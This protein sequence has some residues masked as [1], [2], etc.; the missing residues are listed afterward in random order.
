MRG[1]VGFGLLLTFCAP[2]QAWALSVQPMQLERIVVVE[3]HGV[4]APTKT[5][6][7]L[8]KFSA[9]AWPRWPVGVGELTEHGR[10]NVVRMG[11]WLRDAYAHRRLLSPDGCPD[12]GEVYGWAD[13]QD[14]RTRDSGDALLEGA[15]PGCGFKAHH[16]PPGEQDALFSAT[17]AG[18]CPIDADRAKAAVLSQV[19]GDLDHPG[20]DYQP[21]KAALRDVLAGPGAS[22]C[23]DAKGACFLSAPNALG[24]QDGELK[25]AGPL[26]TASTLTE[27]LLLEY[28]EGMP[29]D[30]VGWG[31]AATVQGI[32]AVMPLHNIE[33][34]LMRRTPYLAEHNG[35]LLARAVLDELEGKRVLPEQDGSSRSLFVLIAGHDTNLSNLAGILGVDWTLK[36]QPDKTPPGAALVFELWWDPASGRHFV[37]V[38]L[39]YQTLEDLRQG[40]VLDASHPA[41]R[42]DLTVPGCDLGSCTV[43]AFRTLIQSRLPAECMAPP[44][45]R[46]A[47]QP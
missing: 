21:A 19:K 23:A 2:F 29:A 34:D 25:M 26:A 3:R 42:V 11:A 36:D 35:V 13:G 27:S 32:S 31:R 41:G 16:A 24:A 45:A 4:R 15:F 8:S 43:E 28:A 9:E 30:Q 39:I 7:A 46:S 47:G 37:N 6:E 17:S 38:A 18:L 12:P 22:P 44:T 14:E 33:T 20:P 5:P 10:E 40:R 1:L